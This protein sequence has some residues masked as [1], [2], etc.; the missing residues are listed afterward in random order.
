MRFLHFQT[1]L[2][3]S[4]YYGLLTDDIILLNCLL[5]NMDQASEIKDQGNAKSQSQQRI[6][7]NISIKSE[8]HA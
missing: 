2:G 6:E 3:P 8:Y 4:W 1:I 5:E 7:L